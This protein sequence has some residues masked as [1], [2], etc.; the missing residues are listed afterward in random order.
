MKK[1]PENTN[2]HSLPS[3]AHKEAKPATPSSTI[4]IYF[5]LTCPSTKS[6]ASSVC[7]TAI[8]L[9]FLC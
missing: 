7:T 2:A 6:S 4:D 8:V 5:P 3:Q 1:T 9:A